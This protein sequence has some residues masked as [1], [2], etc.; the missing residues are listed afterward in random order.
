MVAYSFNRM[1][2]QPLITKRKIGT[3]RA[4]RKRHARVGEEVQLYH[5]MRTKSCTLIG[6]ADCQ[7]VYPIWLNFAA[8]QVHVADSELG[9]GHVRQIENIDAFAQGDGFND[10]P[11]M[12]TFWEGVLHFYGRWIIW[13]DTIRSA[14]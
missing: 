3:I 10:W 8:D 4:D 5:G 14:L 13:N 1:F 9:S 12:R 2:I 11:H 6:R 7:A